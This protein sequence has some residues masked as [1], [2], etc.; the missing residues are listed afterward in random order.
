MPSY[1]KPTDFLES[2]FK[3]ADVFNPTQDPYHATINNTLRNLNQDRL[4]P[5]LTKGVV[6]Y[7]G[8]IL[9]SED[10]EPSFL[11]KWYGSAYSL[12]FDF[13]KPVRFYKVRVPELDGGVI[14]LPEYYANASI[15]S[16]NEQELR[17]LAA[18]LSIIDRHRTMRT[19]VPDDPINDK[20]KP[21]ELVWVLFNNNHLLTEPYITHL[22]RPIG[23]IQPVM[24][25]NLRTP[26]PAPVDT[27]RKP[28]PP[29]V[30]YTEPPQDILKLAIDTAKAAGV[31]PSVLLGIIRVESNWNPKAKNETGADGRY[32][33]AYGLTQLLLKATAQKFEPTVTKEQL[34][35]P[36]VSLRISKR[37]LE[38]NRARLGS[39]PED[40]AAAW[41]S[42]KSFARAPEVTRNE[43]VPKVLAAAKDYEAKGYK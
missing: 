14:P 12:F 11:E 40:V 41:N 37:L 38:E 16:N 19:L 29:A 27:N 26:V 2:S 5:E 8:L 1:P 17:K 7:K 42:G 3:Q 18:S 34:Q 25:N 43:Y 13:N 33:G 6:Y 30:K 36:E 32:G 35:T 28:T 20:L 21:G 15:D 23:N 10:K 39:N 9:K 31:S 22:I 4:T 24:N